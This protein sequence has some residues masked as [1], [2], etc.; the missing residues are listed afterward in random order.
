M[1][2]LNILSYISMKLYLS[3][4]LSLFIFSTS[5]FYVDADGVLN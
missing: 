1:F 2:F 5:T 3:L 4:S